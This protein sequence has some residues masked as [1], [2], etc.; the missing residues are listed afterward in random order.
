MAK[1]LIG[2]VAAIV[3]AAGGYFGFQFYTA[4]PDRRRSRGRVRADSRERRQGKPRQGV[5]RPGSRP[6]RSPISRAKSATQPP[7][8]V[9]IASIIASG[10]GQPDAVPF[11]GRQHR[12]VRHRD[13]RQHRRQRRAPQLQDAT[14]R[15]EGLFRPR[16]ACSGPGFGIGHRRVP[17]GARAIRRHLRIGGLGAQALRRASTSAPSCRATSPIR[18]SRIQD[19]KGGKIAT[20]QVERLA[21]T[22]EHATGRQGRQNDRRITNLSSRDFDAARGCRDPRSAEGERR[23]LLHA[24]TAKHRPVPTPS[25][26]R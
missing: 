3:I 14:G 23:P 10:V 13:R 22:I 6:P 5:V 9:K 12:S 8:S 4:A 11:L 16:P 15:H 1:I 7:V 26:P 17:I 18:A 24:S 19:I 25:R 2:L 21:F 20:M